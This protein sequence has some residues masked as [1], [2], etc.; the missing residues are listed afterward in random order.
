L[1]DD[2]LRIQGSLEEY[3]AAVVKIFG[4]DGVNMEKVKTWVHGLE[5]IG[6]EFDFAAWRVRPKARG[7]AKLAHYLFTVIPVGAS[8]MHEKDLERLCG[9]LTWYAPGIPAGTSFTASFFRCKARVGVSTRRVRLSDVALRDLSW[10]RA[11]VLIV[12]RRPNLLAADIGAVRRIVTP[13][14]FLR[15]DASTLFGGGGYLADSR[16]GPARLMESEGI[17]WT[18][19]E[20]AAFELMAVSI[21]VLEFFVAVFYILLWADEFRGKCVLLECDNIAAVSWLMKKRAVRGSAPTDCLVRL[22]SLFCLR[23]SIIVTSLHIK[24]TDNTIADFRSRDLDYLPQNSD[25]GLVNRELQ[26][27]SAFDGWSRRE[28]CRSVLLLCVMRPAEMLGPR[29]LEL[30]M[31]LAGINGPSTAGSLMPTPTA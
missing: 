29:G 28:L 17:R 4:P 9:L 13:T 1:I 23:E 27:G 20:L 11:L 2:E 15:T 8:T 18:Q 12:A 26:G 3:L 25:E 21:N 6:W 24:G 19:A 10:W 16:G 7:I 30:L 22:L 31:R 5:A 14:V